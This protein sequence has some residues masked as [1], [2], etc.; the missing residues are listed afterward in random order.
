MRFDIMTLFPEEVDAFLSSSII[1]IARKNGLIEVNCH[2][3]RDYST[4]KHHRVDDYPYGGGKGMLMQP[5]PVIKCYRD[6]RSQIGE[7]A[8]CVY[9][10][11]KG[12]HFTQ[13]KAKKLLKKKNLIL[14]CGHYEGIDQR[15]LDAIV[16]EEISIGDYVLSGG[17]LG[18][19]VIVDAVS[20]MV[21]GVL[22]DKSCYE[23]ESIHS[24]LLEYPQYTRPPVY[25]GE[26][27]PDVLLSGD[28]KK[29][30]DWRFEQSLDVTK[31]KRPD[32][33]RRYMNR[34]SVKALMAKKNKK[35]KS[36]KK[37]K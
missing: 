19:M 4:D 11:P 3:I 36:N 26:A 34:A 24:G 31:E 12:R 8:W 5:D 25:E 10:S 33:Y 23:D 20:R 32:L 29:V 21:D 1:G 6:I 35:K 16:D 18:A 9:L 13:T 15:A 22:A 27:V 30:A 2:N 14:L 28:H 7:D 37:H 17:E